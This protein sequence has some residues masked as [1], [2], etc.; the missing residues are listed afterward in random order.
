MSAPG[1]ASK[2]ALFSDGAKA[3]VGQVLDLTRNPSKEA[4]NVDTLTRLEECRHW[5]ELCFLFFHDHL[6]K[7]EGQYYAVARA[8]GKF[9]KVDDVSISW[10]G[11]E[12]PKSLEGYLVNV[13]Y[14][15][16]TNKSSAGISDSIASPTVKVDVITPAPECV[17]V[18]NP[19]GKVEMIM[20][21]PECVRLF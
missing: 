13:G 8:R 19:P 4:A 9:F 16:V 10:N 12:M 5:F 11:S 17:D 1:E 20:P 14:E 6:N 21:A 3:V 15:K 7:Q 2:F 18:A